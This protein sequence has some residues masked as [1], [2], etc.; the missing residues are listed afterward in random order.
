MGYLIKDIDIQKVVVTIPEADV[1][2]MDSSAPFTI[3]Q[4]NASFYAIPVNCFI[5]VGSNQTTAYSGFTHLHLTNSNN[6]SVGDLCATY[7]AN[8]SPTN[9]L[10]LGII[11]SMLCNAQAAPTRIGGININRDLQI[12][13]DTL[14]VAGD[15]DLIVT[16]YY[17]RITI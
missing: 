17:A 4:T 15:G 16:L 1:Q 11:Y 2:I 14:P 12:F 7:A 13:F 3:V 8:A 10:G 6:F 9:D 5:A